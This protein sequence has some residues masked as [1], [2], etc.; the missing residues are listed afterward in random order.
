MSFN[1]HDLGLINSKS[2]RKF[3]SKVSYVQIVGQRRG[4]CAIAGVVCV[5]LG[6]LS[7]HLLCRNTHLSQ[8]LPDRRHLL[9]ADSGNKPDQQE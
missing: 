1:L 6:Q 8:C 7:Q 9:Q 2:F 5:H 3:S 4:N